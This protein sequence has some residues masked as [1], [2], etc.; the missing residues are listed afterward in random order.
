MSSPGTDLDRILALPRK[1]LPDDLAGLM[2]E[3]LRLRPDAPRLKPEQ[4]E[5]LYWAATLPAPYAP[6]IH[7]GVGGGKTLISLLLPHV[8]ESERPV[9]LVPPGLEESTRQEFAF[10]RP[11][12]PVRLPTILT[13]N[14]LSSKT[15]EAQLNDLAPDLLIDD[16]AHSLA[17]LESAR[18][19]RWIRF[20]TANPDCRVV[21]MS[22]TL[23]KRDLARFAHLLEAALGEGSPAPRFAPLLHSLGSV[24]DPKGDPGEN[25]L[26]QA[27]RIVE[28]ATEPGQPKP[29]LLEALNARIAAT[30]GVV[31]SVGSSCDASLHLV[32]HRAEPA[33]ELRAALKQTE[34]TW[35]LPGGELVLDSARLAMH[36]Q[37]LCLGFYY[38][39]VDPPEP[40]WL[41]ARS[42]WHRELRNICLYRD[43]PGFDTPALVRAKLE[44]CARTREANWSAWLALEGWMAHESTPE[45]DTEAVWLDE[46]K[47]LARVVY[48]LQAAQ[49]GPDKALLWYR[50]RAVGER[51]REMGLD[52][53]GAG[54]VAPQGEG[55][56]AC[57]IRR[58]HKGHRMHMYEQAGC[59][60]LVLDPEVWQQLLGRLHRQGQAADVVTWHLAQ[61]GPP[62]EAVLARATMAA[63]DDQALIGEPQKLVFA[64]REHRALAP[65]PASRSVTKAPS[66]V[67]FRLGCG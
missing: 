6:A 62:Q 42:N 8:F 35:V 65:K 18:T 4:A 11:F 15:G 45:P 55:N 30:P 28:W 22:G 61:V 50:S 24:L 10:W 13:Y 23:L 34:D 59:V 60:E 39:W 56:V 31:V 54:D 16:E 33:P 17:R 67:A 20:L 32:T 66:R 41:D 37:N 26:Y 12:Y 53:R 1:E 25:E 64:T 7:Q 63:R 19:R 51:L 29:S 38:R 14:A 49:G 2:T 27:R 36:L 9:L 48:A 57:S 47:T 46:G 21:V 3:V 58:F 52:V 44:R 43:Y 40:E 5:A